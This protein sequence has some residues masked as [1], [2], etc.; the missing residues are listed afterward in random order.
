MVGVCVRVCVRVHSR[1]D[2]KIRTKNTTVAFLCIG[3][4][5]ESLY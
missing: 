2:S 5:S 3:T 4:S 1:Y